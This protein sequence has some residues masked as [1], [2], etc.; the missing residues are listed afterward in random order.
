M[1]KVCRL[2]LLNR[3]KT[4]PVVDRRGGSLTFVGVGI[5]VREGRLCGR[6]GAKRTKT[7]FPYCVTELGIGGHGPRTEGSLVDLTKCLR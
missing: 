2:L 1:P 6:A 5:Q 7:R 4:V 3:T